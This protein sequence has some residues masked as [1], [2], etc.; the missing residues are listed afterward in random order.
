MKHFNGNKMCS[1][2]IRTTGPIPRYH[3]LIDISVIP[4]DYG[5]KRD[6]SIMPFSMY[7][8]PTR[9]ENID[10]E[11]AAKDRKFDN[12]IDYRT[13][14]INKTKL[15]TVCQT[16]V[17]ES[18][19]ADLFVDW[20]EKLKLRNNKKI[21][22]LAYDWA[23]VS[24]FIEDWLGP[25]TFDLYFDERYRDLQQ[26]ALFVNDRASWRDEIVIPF[27][28][29]NFAYIANKCQVQLGTVDDTLNDASAMIDCYKQICQMP[30]N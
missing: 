28:K 18:K 1:V 20:C 11:Q 6:K 22:A 3:D 27:A 29:T 25:K 10:F 15:R 4:M 19:A 13:F 9:L 24:Q 26:A 16:G 30:I 7:V 8:E 12:N 21:L 14:Y 17:E 23:F 2:V 5:L